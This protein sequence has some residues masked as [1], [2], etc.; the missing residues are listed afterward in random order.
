V[1]INKATNIDFTAI[2]A[3][4]VHDMKNSLAAIR[5]RIG[6]LSNHSGKIE[7]DCVLQLEYEANR[8]N[9]SLMQLLTLYKIDLQHFQ[10]QID[11]YSV[12]DILQ[13]IIAQQADLSAF[14]GIEFITECSDELYCYC[15]FNLVCNSVSSI[16]NNAQRYAAN[17]IQL[18]AIEN[19]GYVQIM[20]EDDGTG[21]PQNLLNSEQRTIDRVDYKTGSTGLGLFFAEI[22]ANMHRNGDNNGYVEIANNSCI[23]AGGAKFTLFLP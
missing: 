12:T 23:A 14:D 8:M 17:K 2:L 3:S 20:I 4:S 16:L 9:N 10:L 22:I 6:E 1:T 13:E 7:N 18:S 11:E 21:Y 19:R 15:D 5:S